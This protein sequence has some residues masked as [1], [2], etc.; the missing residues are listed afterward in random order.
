M[1]AVWT[2]GS[3]K[4]P[5]IEEKPHDL[6]NNALWV[7]SHAMLPCKASSGLVRF[8]IPHAIALV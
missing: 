1:W 4:A 7:T 2:S 6:K 3:R 5:G 8:I